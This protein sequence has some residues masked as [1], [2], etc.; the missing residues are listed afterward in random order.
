MSY[1]SKIF[2][3]ELENTQSPSFQAAWRFSA[4]GYNL[5][6]TKTNHMEQDL[7]LQ[8]P[9]SSS[10]ITCVLPSTHEGFGGPLIGWSKAAHHFITSINSP[11]SLQAVLETLSSC[12]SVSES[13]HSSAITIVN[14]QKALTFS[15]YEVFN[16]YSEIYFFF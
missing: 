10:L 9:V 11:S 15:I 16:I 5:L 4:T 13:L 2:V 12:P 1:C 3:L 14:L 7:C 8:W 6:L